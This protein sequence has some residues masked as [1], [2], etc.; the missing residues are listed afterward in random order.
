MNLNTI[1]EGVTLSKV[2]SIKADKDS[3]ES[4]SITLKVKFDGSTLQ[5]VFDKAVAGA[6]IQWQNGPGRRTFD[7]LKNH[8]VITVDFKAPGRTQVDPMTAL[9]LEAKAAGVDVT[10]KAAFAAW[11]TKKA[12]GE[13]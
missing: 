1:V 3:T 5:N 10:D 8:D 7:T 11:I 9:T 4:K 12:M 2:C 13:I 6:V